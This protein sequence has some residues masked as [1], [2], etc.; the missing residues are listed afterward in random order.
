MSEEFVIREVVIA[1]DAEKLATMWKASDDQWPGTWSGGTDIT[2]QMVTEWY[3]REGILNVHV[4]ETADGSKIVGYCSFS[5]CPEEKGAGYIDLLNV[6]P[7]YQ[8]QS[9]ARR[10]L[11]NGVQRCLDLGFHLLTLGTWS[12]N[13]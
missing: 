13:L 3:E 12:G 9:L 5:E 10:L 7:D 4:V 6:Q 2:P 8:K 1:E 11:Q